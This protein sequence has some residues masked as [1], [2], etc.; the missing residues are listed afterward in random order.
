MTPNSGISTKPA[1]SEDYKPTV[2]FVDD[3]EDILNA[4]RRMLRPEPYAQLFALSGKEALDLLSQHSVHVMVSDM[5]MPQMDGV[6]LLE[7]VRDRY[8]EIIRM[9]ISGWADAD[10]ILDAVNNGQIYRYLVKPWEPR[11]LKL[12]L[13]QALE[14]YRLQKERREMIRLLQDQKKGLE[15]SVIQYTDQ[16]M[17]VSQQAEI[18]RNVSQ[19]VRKFNEPLQKLATTIELLGLMSAGETINVAQ[20]KKEVFAAQ[21]GI[22][23]LKQIIAGVLSHAEEERSARPGLLNLNTLIREEL[24][25]FELDAFFHDA[26]RKELHLAPKLPDIMGNSTQIKQILNNLIRN[27]LDA[28]ADTVEKKITIESAV[29]GNAVTVR[30]SD[31]GAGVAPEHQQDIFLKEYSTKAVEKRGGLGLFQIKAMMATYSGTIDVTSAPG[32]GATFRITFP[33][34]RPSIGSRSLS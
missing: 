28:M 25:Y 27:A 15:K 7:T 22:D 18:G 31:T 20:M 21:A 12:T 4:L 6:K 13:R 16:V 17:A 8:P 23:R 5:R 30:I 3:E 26:V 9:V 29:E 11:E 24:Q 32:K 14:M 19:I 33:V 1:D 2:L 34:G 10:A